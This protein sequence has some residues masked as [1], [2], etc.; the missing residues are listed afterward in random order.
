VQQAADGTNLLEVKGLKTYFPIRRGVFKRIVGWV[1]A[2][3]DVNLTV[4]NRETLGLVGESG[5]GKT[6]V[7]RS[8]LRV[9]EPT[10]GE[11]LFRRNGKM[12]EIRTMR[13]Q[14]LREVRQEIRMIF[15]DPQASLNPRFTVRNIIGEP[16]R[17]CRGARGKELDRQVQELMEMVGLNPAHLRRYPHA[18]SGGQRQR[19]GVARAL[20]LRPKLVLADEPTSALDVSVQAQVL[21]LL[22][23]LQEKFDLSYLFISHDLSIIRHISDR[24]AVMYTGRVVETADTLDL[25]AR[26]LHPYTEALFSAV[27]QPDPHRTAAVIRLPGE[28]ADPANLPSGCAFHPRCRYAQTICKEK[29]PAL[30]SI[31]ARHDVACHFAGELQLTGDTQA[32]QHHSKTS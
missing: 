19:I 28:V 5:C 18:F 15:Q 8:L 2:V 20:A 16:L 12:V 10:A 21:N 31:E 3:D 27:P 14:E 17:V 1:R 24:I 30:E 26:P 9:E 23:E 25:F 29:R 13:K 11:V 32:K 6:T 4:G 7:I 22:L